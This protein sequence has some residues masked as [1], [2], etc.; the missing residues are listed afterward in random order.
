M[1]V[2][3]GPAKALRNLRRVRQIAGV[4]VKHGL[5]DIA[6]R[7]SLRSYMPF[8]GKG[9]QAEKLPLADRVTDV[10][11][12]LGPTFVKLG[13]MLSQRPDILPPDFV[14]SFR[15]LQDKVKPFPV[16][17]ARAMAERSLAGS[18]DELYVDFSAQPLASG[19]IAQV[20]AARLPDGTPVVV[21]IRR[22]G[23][24]E[25]MKADLS[26]MRQLAIVAQGQM[27]ELEVYQPVELVEEFARG[28]L[29][30]L[31]FNAEGSAI[32]KF[33][34]FFADDPRIVVPK[35]IWRLTTRDV[36]TLTKLS[37]ISLSDSE[38]LEAAGFDRKKFATL[39]AECFMRQFFELGTF[40]GDPHPGNLL[41]I[42]G[43]KLGLLD[44]GAVGHLSNEM[45]TELGAIMYAFTT[46]DIDMLINVYEEI[47]VVGDSLNRGALAADIQDFFDRYYGLPADRISFA[48][49]F[50]DVV[51][52]AR[53]HD[54][55]LPRELVVFGRVL[56]SGMSSVQ[57]VDPEVKVSEILGGYVKRLMLKKLSPHELGRTGARMS[58]SLVSLVRHLPEDAR[59]IM[60]KLRRGEL[61]FRFQHSGLEA[62]TTEIDR[63]SNRLA[64][65]VVI[66]AIIIGS[67]SVM[68]MDVGPRWGALDFL[69]L[70][71]VPIMGFMGFLLA[72]IMGLGLAWSIFRSGALSG[73]H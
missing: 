71:D 56:V 14:K 15:R 53:R 66:A 31:D 63:A 62:F 60:R 2:L 32:T 58:Y 64:F 13:Q 22:P 46:R 10:L 30:E 3:T 72:G 34:E 27:P 18:L 12:E 5:S 48:K 44:F 8:F 28:L 19:S 69:G 21:K 47:G 39:M 73:R 9:R 16:D 29:K 61:S 41:L 38:A 35:V 65:S 36:A 26:L 7:L 49:A 67:S 59:S 68:A 70:G 55:R 17:Q 25:E 45:I 6:E 23:I 4:L 37:G 20:H 40:H 24:E 33:G 52:M 51:E 43:E 11:Q 1:N 50:S 54:A 42:D 57:M